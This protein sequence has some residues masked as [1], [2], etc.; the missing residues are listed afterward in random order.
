MT[1][2]E[3]HTAQHTPGPWQLRPAGNGFDIVTADSQGRFIPE[4]IASVPV[5]GYAGSPRGTNANAELIASAPALLAERDALREILAQCLRDAD[6]ADRI[7]GDDFGQSLMDK[8]TW[9]KARAA[10]AQGEKGG[11]R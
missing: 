2:N 11:G 5:D 1:T 3:K 4:L 7:Y 10:L 8:A 6:E 9:N